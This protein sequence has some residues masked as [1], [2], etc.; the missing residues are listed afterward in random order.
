MHIFFLANILC[1]M[2]KTVD[3]F[4]MFFG[5]FQSLPENQELAVMEGRAHTGQLAVLQ[6]VL[7]MLFPGLDFCKWGNE[8]GE[9]DRKVTVTTDTECTG[10]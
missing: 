9:A 1:H 7:L 6:S 3:Y 5:G 4:K 10:T 8:D 2:G